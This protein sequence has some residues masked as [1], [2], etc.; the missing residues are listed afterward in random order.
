[1]E[2]E[3]E[4]QQPLLSSSPQTPPSHEYDLANSISWF[5][6]S[7]SYERRNTSYSG[8][9]AST[10][11]NMSELADG[12]CYSLS[13]H[14]NPTPAS[15]NVL[16]P[17]ADSDITESF[18]SVRDELLTGSTEYLPATDGG[19]GFTYGSGTG[20]PF[21]TSGGVVTQDHR[22][23]SGGSRLGLG[24][25]RATNTGI[26][27]T[28][29]ATAAAAAAHAAAAAT[30]SLLHRQPYYSVT[31]T[32]P[33][34]HSQHRHGSHIYDDTV[35]LNVGGKIFE[36][37]RATLFRLPTMKLANTEEM[38]KYYRPERREYFF[39]RDSEAFRIIL[40]YL[41]TGE[42]HVPMCMC[43]PSI[44]TEFEFW[45]IEEHDIE[46][47]CWTQYN[48]WNTQSK[49]LEKLE[50]FRKTSLPQNGLMNERRLSCWTRYRAKI[51]SFLNDPTSS[52]Y[53]QN[54]CCG[55]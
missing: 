35:V 41:R 54:L 46:R 4:Q 14:Q 24:G 18:R 42:L 20:N 17:E 15:C 52:K 6:A 10:I 38:E 49:S 25:Y 48:T 51:W 31:P 39:D 28:V 13:T 5:T 45:G 3:R 30:N 19:F 8:I 7:E 16:T 50:S 55:S 44:K 26:N 34:S 32:T 11:T 27:S 43:G 9:A 33:G 22:R 53:A 29:A 36:T 12:S 2:E 37:R 40:N 21:V 1:M 47:C 23:R